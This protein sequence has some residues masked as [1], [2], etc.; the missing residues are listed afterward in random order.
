MTGSDS[1]SESAS[2]YSKVTVED[3]AEFRSL[4]DHSFSLVDF[5]WTKE[6]VYEVEVPDE[7]TPVGG[8]LVIR[9][10]TSVDSRDGTS[11]GRGG[12]SMSVKLKHEPTDALCFFPKKAHRLPTWPKN[13]RKK[14]N[15]LLDKAAELPVCPECGRALVLRKSKSGDWFRGC[16]GFDEDECSHV[17]D[18]D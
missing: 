10:F 15:D 8:T 12:D 14:I 16:A 2:E 6:I 13:V 3:L 11:R 4:S 5:D 7:K 9:W 18:L 1:G 17:Q